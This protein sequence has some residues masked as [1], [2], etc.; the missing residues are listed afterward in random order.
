MLNPA[1]SKPLQS[2]LNSMDSTVNRHKSVAD[3]KLWIGIDEI[4]IP[5]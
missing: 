3:G 5:R 1:R 2:K 4:E